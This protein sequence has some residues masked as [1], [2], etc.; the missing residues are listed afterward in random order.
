MEFLRGTG[1]KSFTIGFGSVLCGLFFL[2]ISAL[3]LTFRPTSH[4]RVFAVLSIALAVSVVYVGIQYQ[5]LTGQLTIDVPSSG[6]TKKIVI[7]AQLTAAAQAYVQKHPE[8]LRDVLL[9]FGGESQRESVWPR[10]SI[11]S[12]KIRLS[13]WFI[14]LTVSIAGSLFCLTELLVR[15]Q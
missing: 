11:N 3:S 15:P 2:G 5:Q 9:D 13:N 14:A 8:P 4:K 7:G 10:E 1:P 12:A 6:A